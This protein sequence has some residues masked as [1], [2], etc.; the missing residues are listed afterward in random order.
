MFGT[1]NTTYCKYIISK[2]DIFIPGEDTISTT[3]FNIG[4]MVIEKDFDNDIH[5][6]IDLRLA[7]T[8]I[9]IF[10]IISHK[11][12]VRFN[13]RLDKYT[14][15]SDGDDYVSKDKV[16]DDIFVIYL[17]DNSVQLDKDLYNVTKSTTGNKVD[18]SDISEVY[19][20][21][22]FK[23]N[24][25]DSARK[26]INTVIEKGTMTDVLTYLLNESECN[27]VLMAPLD[28]HNT[29][30]NVI[31]YPTTLINNINAL[32]NSYGLYRHGALLFFDI[33]RTYLINKR[34][35]SE[36]HSRDEYTNVMIFIYKSKSTLIYQGGY[37]QDNK[38]RRYNI[39]I[40]TSSITMKTA[41]PIANVTTGTDVILVDSIS[42]SIDVVSPETNHRGNTT[43]KVVDK[44]DIADMTNEF[45]QNEINARISEQDSIIDAV[46]TGVD[47]GILTPN[48][49]FTFVFEDTDIQK[50]IGGVYRL[51]KATSSLS[52]KNSELNVSSNCTFYKIK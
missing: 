8:P 19:D 47:V 43:S 22:L 9:D 34:G 18:L 5:P 10:N 45:A 14:Y 26:I 39:N 7:L 11:N 41:S 1:T 31:L 50:Q 23:E 33:P 35:E 25:I 3:K 21:F 51:V 37:Q 52:P 6:V 48:K 15:S 29:Y 13:I 32:N 27:N 28:N 30:E 49:R 40:V 24:D 38:N 42:D 16:F 46:F 12:D 36:V 4:G 20:F 44:L 17:D 2:L